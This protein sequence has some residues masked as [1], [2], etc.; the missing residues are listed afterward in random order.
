MAIRALTT[1]LWTTR[2]AVVTLPAH[3]IKSRDGE[4]NVPS[5]MGSLPPPQL[6]KRVA[7]TSTPG[8]S[9]YLNQQ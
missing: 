9:R 1:P 4:V 7:V 2:D 3:Q 6:G 5:S 8:H